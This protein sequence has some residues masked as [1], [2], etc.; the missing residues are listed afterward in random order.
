MTMEYPK[1]IFADFNNADK[2]GRVRL[3]TA[4]TLTDLR[5]FG[6]K[7]EAGLEL[8]LDD[9]EGLSTVGIVELSEEENIWVARINWEHF[10][11]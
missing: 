7:L 5:K 1:K 9:E 3:T 8:L 10:K 6:L 2:K 4:G 11:T